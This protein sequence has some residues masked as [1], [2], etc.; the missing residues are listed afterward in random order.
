MQ[1]GYL[2]CLGPQDAERGIVVCLGP[3]P[4]FVLRVGGF[5]LAHAR[6]PSSGAM[7]RAMTR[8]SCQ[9]YKPNRSTGRV[10]PSVA[11]TNCWAPV[12]REHPVSACRAASGSLAAIQYPPSRLRIDRSSS[13]RVRGL[14]PADCSEWRGLTASSRRSEIAA[15]PARPSMRSTQSP[16]TSHSS[17]ASFHRATTTAEDGERGCAT[18][19]VLRWP[20]VTSWIAAA[21]ASCRGRPGIAAWVRRWSASCRTYH[22]SDVGSLCACRLVPPRRRVE[23]QHSCLSRRSPRYCQQP[24]RTRTPT[25]HASV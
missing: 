18:S 6:E 13:N 11:R 21:R 12:R 7:A 1:P 22:W 8:R 9:S 4:P 2:L 16:R 17:A 19:H 15:S 5:D 24:R 3:R 10:A 20:F 25:Q 23:R 14:R